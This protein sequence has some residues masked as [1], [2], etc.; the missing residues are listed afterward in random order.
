VFAESVYNAD[1]RNTGSGLLPRRAAF[2]PRSD[3]VG[4]VVDKVALGFLSHS[5]HVLR[6][7]LKLYQKRFL[8]HPFRFIISS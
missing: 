6:Q 1:I 5:R 3:N 7:Y 4:L 2:D 8:P